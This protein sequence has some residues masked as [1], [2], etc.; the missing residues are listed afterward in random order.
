MD[1]I[2]NRQGVPIDI[3]EFGRLL[4]DED[5][6]VL[7]RTPAG[8]AVVSTV[9]LGMDVGLSAITGGEPIIFETMIYSDDG[10]EDYQ[11]RYHTEEEALEGHA[12]VV[13]FLSPVS[14]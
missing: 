13:E 4:Q 8:G 6:V 10:W 12:E 5:Y 9:W 2:F 3:F 11:A 1:Y 14:S 7:G